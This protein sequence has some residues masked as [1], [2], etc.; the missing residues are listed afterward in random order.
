VRAQD[1]KTQ[2]AIGNLEKICIPFRNLAARKIFVAQL[3]NVFS[4]Q[5]FEYFQYVESVYD[6]DLK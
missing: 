1:N 6:K 5:G 3:K 4:S 2:K